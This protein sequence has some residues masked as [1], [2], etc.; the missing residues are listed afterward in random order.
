MLSANRTNGARINH[1]GN[2]YSV[3]KREDDDGY[4]FFYL[5]DSSGKVKKRAL[6]GTYTTH[7]D[8]VKEHFGEEYALKNATMF[9]FDGVE[10]DNQAR[11]FSNDEH[12]M[13]WGNEAKPHHYLPFLK[14]MVNAIQKHFTD[15]ESEE[16]PNMEK[17]WKIE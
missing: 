14:G 12:I 7:F 10:I 9:N 11:N 17:D 16:A 15:P 6:D 2:E 4:D 13:N 3:G 8:M 1:N 5:V